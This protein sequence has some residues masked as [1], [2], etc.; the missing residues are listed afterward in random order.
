MRELNSVRLGDQQVTRGPSLTPSLSPTPSATPTLTLTTITTLTPTLTP[1]LIPTPTP[2]QILTRSVT[3]AP[4]RALP[5]LGGRQV[6]IEFARNKGKN[7]APGMTQLTRTRIPSFIPN[8][9]R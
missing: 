1:T 6:K 2:T 4:T 7:A 8:A 5:R 3:R 9:Q